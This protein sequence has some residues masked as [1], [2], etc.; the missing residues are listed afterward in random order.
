M[1]NQNAKMVLVGNPTRNIGYFA[2]SFGD[3]KF[4]KIHISCWDSP[5]VKENKIIYPGLVTR[6]WCEEKK[7][8]WGEDSAI[9][10]SRVL[11]NIPKETEDT[12]IRINW[13]EASVIRY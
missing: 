4:A 2:E 9:Y 10:Q 13:I 1:A 8:S 5:N 12:L 7:E 11:G 3:P 6:E